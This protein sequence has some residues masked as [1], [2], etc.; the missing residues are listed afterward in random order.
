M[1]TFN[2]YMDHIAQT[3]LNDQFK[4]EAWRAK[5]RTA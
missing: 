4:A 2:N 3:P 1:K 5:S